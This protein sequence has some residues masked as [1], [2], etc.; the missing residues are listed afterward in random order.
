MPNYTLQKLSALLKT[1]FNIKTA[2]YYYCI[3]REQK[4]GY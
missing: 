2:N 4:K 3:N 1:L